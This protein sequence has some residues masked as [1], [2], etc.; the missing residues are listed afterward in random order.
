MFNSTLSLTIVF[1]F[2]ALEKCRAI[3]WFNSFVILNDKFSSSILKN[4]KILITDS[5]LP[6]FLTHVWY[7]YWLI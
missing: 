5:K 7:N 4:T 3:V 6:F 2:Q 1:F